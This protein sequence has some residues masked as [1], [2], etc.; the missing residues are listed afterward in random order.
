[1]KKPLGEWGADISKRVAGYSNV[2]R[3]VFGEDCGVGTRSAVGMGSLP[4]GLAVEIEALFLCGRMNL[5]C[6]K[7]T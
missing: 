5:R 2:M 6:A 7:G 3:D 4:G 1:M